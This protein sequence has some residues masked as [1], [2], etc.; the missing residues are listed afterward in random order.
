MNYSKE[1]TNCIT[2][3][4]PKDFGYFHPIMMS[5]EIHNYSSCAVVPKG[6]ITVERCDP[7]ST[8]NKNL[9]MENN[10]TGEFAMREFLAR[11]YQIHSFDDLKDW[12]SN[13]KNTYDPTVTRICSCGFDVFVTS[14]NDVVDDIITFFLVVFRNLKTNVLRNLE[15]KQLSKYMNMY[16]KKDDKYH[17]LYHNVNSWYREENS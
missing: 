17:G 9:I 6:D 11:F 5:P 8:I 7:N 1:P 13:N 3:C 14:E 12:Y 10:F 2:G 16:L 4:Y 15:Y